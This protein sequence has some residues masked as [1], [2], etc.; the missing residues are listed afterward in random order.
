MLTVKPWSKDIEN[1]FKRL[2]KDGR[3]FTHNVNIS[4]EIGR[5]CPDL[6]NMDY[7]DLSPSHKKKRYWINLLPNTVI[8][9]KPIKDRDKFLKFSFIKKL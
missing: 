4:R 5:R 3:A 2:Q 6:V 8:E 7:I 1:I 9:E